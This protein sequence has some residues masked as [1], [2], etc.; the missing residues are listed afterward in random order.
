[1]VVFG[2]RFVEVCLLKQQCMYYAKRFFWGKKGLDFLAF[3]LDPAAAAGVSL[4]AL[5][6]LTNWISLRAIY[7]NNTTDTVNKALEII[8]TTSSM[9]IFLI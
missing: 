8:V 1:M 5:C 3:A 7:N 6:S 4:T 2:L 9:S